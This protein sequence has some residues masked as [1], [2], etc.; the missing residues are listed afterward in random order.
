MENDEADGEAESAIGERGKDATAQKTK[1][2]E[3][4]TS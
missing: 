2:R 1:K 3:E 4:A